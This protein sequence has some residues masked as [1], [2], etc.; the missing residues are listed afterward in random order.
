MNILKPTF[1][2]ENHYVLSD[3]PKKDFYLYFELEASKA[4][5]ND[6]RIPLNISLVVDRSGS[7]SGDKLNYVKKAV[8]FVI[9]NLAGEDYLSIVQYDNVVDVVSPSALVT[10]KSDLHKKVQ[11]IEA[12]GSTNLSGGML[13]GYTQVEQTKHEQFVNRVLLL[14]DG[15]ANQGI[16]EPSK[17]QEIALK[18]FRELGLGLSTFGVG[19]DFNEELMTNLSEYGG[20]N[21][22]FIESPDKIPD[23]FAEELKGLLSVV[24]QNSKL[25]IQFPSN[26]F[27]C[28][29]VFGYPYQ[30]IQNEISVNFN[31]VFSEE[32]KAVLIKLKA[33]KEITETLNFEAKLSYEDVIE[34]LEKIEET[35]S[36][37]ISPTQDKELFQSRVNQT[38]IEQI[39]MF[40][41]NDMFEQATQTADKRDFETAKKLI[42]Q[43]KI[44]LE[45]HFQV[46]PANEELKQLYQNVLNYADKLKDMENMTQMD[47]MMSQKMSKMAIYSQKRKK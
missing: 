12:R 25:T 35:F 29:K 42:E 31:D 47:Y 43:V 44:Y 4:P 32:K 45:K 14:S 9:D 37:Q 28:E 6:Q 13:E 11:K 23:I 30:V 5:E 36:L 2:T 10:N 38:V 39:T 1:L 33:K 21:Y 34:K 19:A 8:D 7:M 41:A 20:G 26:E 27:T 22:Y 3:S 46:I 16:R 40:E 18:K 15:L 17:L 24:A